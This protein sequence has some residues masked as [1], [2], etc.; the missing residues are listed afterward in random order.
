MIS[1]QRGEGVAYHV[2]GGACKVRARRTAVIGLSGNRSEGR[3][4]PKVGSMGNIS[5][6][7]YQQGA[8]QGI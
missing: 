7:L 2:G 3:S 8:I 5:A 4:W 6:I 1:G